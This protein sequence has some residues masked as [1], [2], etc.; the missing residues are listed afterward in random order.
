LDCSKPL[1]LK[2]GQQDIE[3]SYTA[4][5]FI[6]PEKMRFRYKL[7]GLDRD[8]IEAGERRLAYYAN[9][10]PGRYTFR[11]IACNA[12]GVWNETG[13]SVQV[14]LL[15]H[16]YQTVWFRLLCGVAVVGTVFGGYGWRLRHLTRKQQALQE[17]RDSPGEK[18]RRTHR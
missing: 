13:A 10:K 11:V 4:I 18:G 1:V 8:W 15:P 9:L 16:F 12:D 5:S 2:P 6:S 17:A 14:E 3:F 7:E